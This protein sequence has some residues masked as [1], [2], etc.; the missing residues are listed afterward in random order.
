[1]LEDLRRRRTLAKMGKIATQSLNAHPET[2]LID[3]E[4]APCG[5]Q[6]YGCQDFLTPSECDGLMQQ[7]DALAIPSTVYHDTPENDYRTSFSSNLH[8]FDPLVHDIDQRICRLMGLDSDYS[9]TIQGQRY[10]KGQYF[11]PHQDFFHT[12]MEY[13]QDEKIYGGQRSWTAMAYLND[14]PSGGETEFR[15]IGIVIKP[16]RGTLIMWNNMNPDGT[17]NALTLHSGNPVKKGMKYIITK[18][19]REK[20]WHAR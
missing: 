19:F 20:K 1:M 7:I 13:W 4:D 6:I 15:D 11:K 17:P 3:R 18:W 8:K 10:A 9:E 14:T 16:Q 12:N 5:V 2:F